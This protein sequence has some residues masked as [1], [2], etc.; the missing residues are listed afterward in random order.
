MLVWI[1]LFDNHGEYQSTLNGVPIAGPVRGITD[2]SWTPRGARLNMAG[3]L[4]FSL[5]LAT[6]RAT[7]INEGTFIRLW[8]DGIDQGLFIV[9]ENSESDDGT[10]ATFRCSDLMDELRWAL[11][12]GYAND[13]AVGMD[14]AASRVIYL[15]IDHS[16]TWPT[17]YWSLIAVPG[18]TG[19]YTGTSFVVEAD[20]ALGALTNLSSQ[21]GYGF[22][23][24][25]TADRV[26][27]FG[28]LREDSG[29]RLQR[30]TG[31]ASASPLTLLR[32]II[33]LVPTRDAQ[34]IVTI[35][36]PQSQGVDGA[37]LRDIWNPTGAGSWFE[38]ASGDWF[39][40]GPIL[41]PWYHP[42]FPLI[43]RLRPDG[44]LSDGQDGWT[45]FVVNGQERVAK[46]E[47]WQT[48]VFGDI[49][50]ASAFFSDRRFAAAAL[51]R[52]CVAFLQARADAHRSL[53]VTTTAISDNRGL[54][55][56]DVQVVDFR[57]AINEFR[58]VVDVTRS[59][60]N[61]GI[62]T[63][64][65]TLDNI[66]RLRRDDRVI[67]SETWRQ[68]V[69]LATNPRPAIT[70]RTITISGHV[71]ALGSLHFTIP[72]NPI[73]VRTQVLAHVAPSA[74]ASGSTPD[75]IAMIA[76]GYYFGVNRTQTDA[77]FD[78]DIT[79]TNGDPGGPNPGPAVIGAPLAIDSLHDL[80]GEVPVGKQGTI[81]VTITISYRALR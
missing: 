35:V 7:A 13:P 73:E 40:T 2:I 55:G 43:R 11:I 41:D 50:P 46:R 64:R 1:D 18:A 8:Q 52:A 49:R 37:N 5:A 70:T 34:S 12:T 75:A 25:A 16:H 74:D 67:I 33:D 79:Y 80:A 56:T 3:E 53:D 72:A 22:R 68:M 78:A 20:S 29:I 36:A 71:P 6:R 21:T 65:W 28:D 38:I 42:E 19:F 51:Y 81:T 77:A 10:V 63:D 30:G 31:N 47:R 27:D 9:G 17:G 66:G 54:A 76:G 15:A 45:Y 69:A 57:R 4:T 14:A 62:G 32:P 61:D 24:N 26:I 48:Q 44:K 39:I 23:L 60:S 58:T 59:V